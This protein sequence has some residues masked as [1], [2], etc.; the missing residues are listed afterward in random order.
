MSYVFKVADN[1]QLAS[2]LSQ[3]LNLHRERDWTNYVNQISKL[4]R[5]LK[6]QDDSTQRKIYDE[7]YNRKFYLIQ[8]KMEDISSDT[9]EGNYGYIL[10]SKANQV[11]LVIPMHSI[12][13]EEVTDEGVATRIYEL[14]L[15]KNIPKREASPNDM[16]SILRSW[17]GDELDKVSTSINDMCPEFLMK[18]KSRSSYSDGRFRSYIHAP[19]AYAFK[20][21][22]LNC[23]ATQLNVEEKFRERN[24]IKSVRQEQK[25]AKTLLNLS[26]FARDKEN[27]SWFPLVDVFFGNGSERPTDAIENAT[28][29]LAVHNQISALAMMVQ[30]ELSQEKPDFVTIQAN[31]AELKKL[32]DS[33]ER[34]N[35]LIEL[36]LSLSGIVAAPLACLIGIVW[37]IPAYL[38]DLPYLGKASF[39]F[40]AIQWGIDSLITAVRCLILPIAMIHAYNTT[41]SSNVLK[42]ECTRIVEELISRIKDPS[43]GSLIEITPIDNA[44][45]R[46]R[47]L[48]GY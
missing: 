30:A 29:R 25:N 35:I 9:L 12:C 26:W 45:F 23:A 44:T 14:I 41:G 36:I 24:G 21:H 33:H 20:K 48:S 32:L 1:A 11:Y 27:F 4:Y 8:Q 31:L 15:Q 10:G 39:F 34:D 17:N 5:V 7:K 18:Q 19:S 40:D 3:K 28:P 6:E 42:G 22:I 2:R 16:D 13:F 47:T 37:I 46:N 43:N 38:C